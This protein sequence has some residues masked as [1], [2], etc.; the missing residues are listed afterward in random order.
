MRCPPLA[1]LSAS[2]TKMVLANFPAAGLSTYN[3]AVQ[4]KR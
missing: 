1:K 3:A 2:R 4:S